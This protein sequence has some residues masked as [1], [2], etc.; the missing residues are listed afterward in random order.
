MQNK[1]I[2]L[3]SASPRRNELLTG[4]IKEFSVINSSFDESTVPT[5]YQPA[6]HVLYSSLMKA[7][8]VAAENPDSLIIGADTVVAFDNEIMGK[9]YD[10]ND[11]IRML[12]KLSGKTHQVL[13]GISIISSSNEICEYESTDV[14]FAPITK[15]MIEEYVSTGE[16]MDKA[17]AYGIQGKGAILVKTINGCYFNVVGL[18][19]YK[20][21]CMLQKLGFDILFT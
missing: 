14:T 8:C 7:R 3:A 10:T 11:A 21:S 20:L 4:L 2:I 19:L 5:H 16:P 9:P 15:K 17:G 1:K 12:S 13:T 18:P 6:K